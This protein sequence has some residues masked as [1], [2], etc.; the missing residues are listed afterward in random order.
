MPKEK[1]GFTRGNNVKDPC[2]TTTRIPDVKSKTSDQLLAMRR[3]NPVEAENE[4]KGPARFETSTSTAHNAAALAPMG[5]RSLRRRT[6]A[7]LLCPLPLQKLACGGP[8]LR[9]QTCATRT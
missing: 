4:G 1:T 3:A 5:S 2:S 9:V 6:R 8:M 7:E